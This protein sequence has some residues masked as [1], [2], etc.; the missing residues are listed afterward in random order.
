MTPMQ[1]GK[2]P[3]LPSGEQY[4][5]Q[6]GGQRAVIVEVG[7]GIREYEVDGQPL[8]DGYTEQE[9]VGGGRG[10]VLAPWPNRL[11]D[12]AY[13]LDGQTYQLGLSE[14]DKRN[15]IHGLVRWANWL[16]A[17]REPAAVRMRLLLHPR[18]GYPFAI[19]MEVEYRLSDR[20][21]SVSATARNVGQ[22][23]A[24]YGIAHHP[25]LTAGTELV[26]E[27]ELQVPASAYLELDDR[28][29]PTGRL[30][31]VEG[32]DYDFRQPRKIGGLK[33][34]TPFA[35]LTPYP[36][37]L[38]RVHL[39]GR[40]QLSLWF[41][42]NF[43]FVQAFTGD[44]VQ[45]PSRRRQGLAVEPMTCAPDAFHNGLGLRV[46]EPGESLTTT[47]GLTIND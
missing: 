33:L 6:H 4:E 11:R 34:D 18:V 27:A 7:A 41:D 40:R 16:C 15:A 39:N 35:Q 32:T 36:D 25:Y 8:L 20:G 42:R 14:P 46:L 9:M 26:D 44:T 1:A 24:P 43:E 28:A 23:R 30:L 47:W 21:L 19:S 2:P 38:A 13:E 10:A 3:E 12:G 45:P 5:S 31:P 29:V 22:Q 17:A 37:G